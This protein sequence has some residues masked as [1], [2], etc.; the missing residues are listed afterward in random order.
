MR[1]YLNKKNTEG[2][3]KILASK[4]NSEIFGIGIV[5]HNAGEL[6]NEAALA[7]EMGT[8]IE[9]LSLTIHAHPT[10]SESIS[11]TAEILDG[12]ITDLYIPKNK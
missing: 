4:D 2:K 9:D 3:T 10:L 7:I 6:I 1:K 8:S 11:N 5:G 12:T